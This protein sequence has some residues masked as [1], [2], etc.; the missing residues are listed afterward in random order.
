[1]NK[2]MDEDGALGYYIRTFQ[3]GGCFRGVMASERLG[4]SA[5]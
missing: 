2:D 5:A 3:K 4:L 1:M